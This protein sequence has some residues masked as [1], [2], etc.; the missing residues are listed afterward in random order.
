M[1]LPGVAAGGSA[2]HERRRVSNPGASINVPEWDG[3]PREAGEVWTLR[4]RKHVACCALWTHPYGGEARVTVDGELS[5]SEAKRDGLALVNLA[6]EWNVQFQEKG[7]TG[8]LSGP[9]DTF[10]EE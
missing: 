5:R 9:V 2:K 10:A 8:V 3:Q 4:R 7:W 6:L 1:D